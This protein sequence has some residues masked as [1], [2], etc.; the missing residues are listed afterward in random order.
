MAHFLASAQQSMVTSRRTQP[1]P[2]DFEHA[3]RTHNLTL[4]TLLPH[5]DP[6]VEKTKTQPL[7]RVGA[8]SFPDTRAQD[9]AISRLLHRPAAADAPPPPPQPDPPREHLARGFPTLPSDHTYKATPVYTQ[10]L[11]DAKTIRERATEEGRRGEEAL[12]KLASR[13]QVLEAKRRAQAVQQAQSHQQQQ[14]QTPGSEQKD[15]AVAERTVTPVRPLARN[16][17]E[18]LF[19]ETMDAV[20][21]DYPPPKQNSR[22]GTPVP[23]GDGRLAPDSARALWLAGHVP[24]AVNWDRI[25]WRKVPKPTGEQRGAPMWEF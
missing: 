10:R 14:Q 6:P 24:P 16:R 25:H 21:R 23:G 17:T 1:I 4:S 18:Q 19:R 8:Q 2:Q 11:L 12:R 3:L 15:L 20:C 13:R 7:L 22:E 5:L 9:A